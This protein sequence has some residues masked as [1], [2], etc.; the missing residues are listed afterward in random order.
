MVDNR[1]LSRIAELYYID[2]MNQYQ[3]AQKFNLSKS[4][5]C[6]LIKKAKEEKI[7]QFSIKKYYERS[8]DI[9]KK[10]EDKFNIKEVIVYFNPKD[11]KYEENLVFKKIGSLG[12]EYIKRILRDGIKIAITW[13]ETLYW[14]IKQI[15]V[16]KK[17]NVEIFSTLGGLPLTKAEFQNNNLVKW[18][19]DKIGGNYY[20]IYLPLVL[21]SSEQK[22]IFYKEYI[23]NRNFKDGSELDYYIAGAGSISKYSRIYKFG[24]FSLEDLEK[25]QNQGIIGEIGLNFFNNNGEFVRTEID[26][27]IIKLDIKEIKKI[28]NKIVIAFGKEK[29]KALRGLLKS[30]IPDALITDSNMAGQLLK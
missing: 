28:K 21:N 30:G 24:G 4:K 2:D 12:A 20:L 1:I 27:K 15:N 8:I 26:E 7:I 10:L 19:S 18:L 14:L 23:S 5:V 3:I 29:V 11:V 16:E 6:R 13:G 9:E 25:L 17:Y 22:E